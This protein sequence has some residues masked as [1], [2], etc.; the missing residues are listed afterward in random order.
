MVMTDKFKHEDKLTTF[1]YGLLATCIIISFPIAVIQLFNI[2][3]LL[4]TVAIVLTF[5]CIIVIIYFVGDIIEKIL[6]E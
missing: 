2:S 6:V 3:V 5:A 1:G 4:T